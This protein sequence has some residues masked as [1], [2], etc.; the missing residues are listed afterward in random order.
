VRVPT[1]AGCYINLDRS[2]ERAAFMQAQLE[3]LG[4]HWVQRLAATDAQAAALP[5][6]C[7]LLPGEYACFLSHLRAVET[8]PEDGFMLVLEDDTELS[9]Q[10]PGMLERALAAPLPGFDIALLECQPHFSLA[11]VSELWSAA[12]RHFIG[13]SRR[14]AGIDLLDAAQYYKW[15]TP[16]YLVPPGARARLLARMRAWLAEGPQLP[17]DRR[18]ERALVAGELQG[19]ITVPFL[20]TTGLQWHG[21]S[22]IGAGDR[23]PPGQLMV[24]RRLL[25]AG[26]FGAVESLL[27]RRASPGDERLELFG[28]V[29]RELAARQR[30]DAAPQRRRR[31]A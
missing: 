2:P 17:I 21:R 24:L 23:L 20:V 15:G 9:D 8:A 5:P 12:A 27:P 7:P 14:V 4:L 1:L 18:L 26:E 6:G 30:A 31:A 3:R 16:G 10:L 25:F 19:V 11:H 22:E 28:L 13:A 29:L